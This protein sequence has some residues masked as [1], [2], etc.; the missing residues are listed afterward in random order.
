MRARQTGSH[1]MRADDLRIDARSLHLA[2]GLH[3]LLH[4]DTHLPIV[5]VNLWYHV[6]SKNEREGRTGFAHLFEHMMFQGSAHVAVNGFFQ[7]V[8]E[9]GGTLNGSTSFDRTN[10][11][12]TL[13]AHQLA[14]ALW[15]ESD[16]MRSLALTSETLENQRSV[17]M[18]ERR[19]RYDNQPYGTFYEE[20]FRR[21][22]TV[23]PY[24][25]STI[26]SMD[27]IRAA[28]LE[29][30][31]AFHAEYYRPSNAS[32]CI[33]GDFDEAEAERLVRA[34][35]EDI[36]D[37]GP[38]PWRPIEREPAQTAM[39][40]DVYHDAVP[41]PS[42]GMAFHIPDVNHRDFVAYEALAKILSSG[43]SS[44]LHRAIVYDAR[45]AQSVMTFAFGLELPGVFLLRA[46]AQPGATTDEIE[47]IVWR[48]F[49]RVRTGGVTDHELEKAKNRMEASFLHQVTSLQG[50][51]DALNSYHVLGGDAMRINDELGQI[52][53]VTADDVQRV[54]AA[55][56]VEHNATVLAC[57]PHPTSTSETA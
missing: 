52:R 6:G 26:G 39:R 44:R 53:A 36:P 42:L 24:R 30:V 22:W 1:P 19:S 3:V 57:L 18:E 23:Q 54:A 14:L 10:Y 48:E 45:R 37:E 11:F 28:T 55:S 56:L 29:E 9:A 32:L 17:V 4:R 47:E 50:R 8:Q 12:E 15:L 40:R 27:D 51:A 41:L 43:D 49:E 31:Q 33:A 7:H 2:N 38:A 16:R 35:F 5:A 34:Y 46:T 21:T 25:H 20:L 13:P